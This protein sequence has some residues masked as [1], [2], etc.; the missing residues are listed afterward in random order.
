MSERAQRREPV[1]RIRYARNFVVALLLT[2]LGLILGG[3]LP[4]HLFAEAPTT[5]TTTTTTVPPENPPVISSVVA[6]DVTDGQWADATPW[7][8]VKERPVIEYT[9]LSARSG[10]ASPAYTQA[11]AVWMRVH[12]LSFGL[13]PGSTGPGR[14]PS[15]QRGPETVPA[16]GRLNLLGYFNSG[17][18]EPPLVGGQLAGFYTNKKTFFPFT[19]G[20]ATLVTYV[21]GSADVI[22][23]PYGA[24]VPSNVVTARQNLT[25]MVANH[26]VVNLGKNFYYWGLTLTVAPNGWRSGIGVDSRGNLIYAAANYQSPASLAALFVRLGAVRAME[27]DINQAWPL[28]TTFSAPNAVGGVMR[29]ANPHQYV[30]RFLRAGTT[31]DFV[32]VYRRNKATVPPPW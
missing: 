12:D 13:Y 1:L 21:D 27:L 7:A 32:A 3:M 11:Y 2:A 16:T 6:N 30:D 18:Y 17:F 31:K 8:D 10:V 26:H 19:N 29:I 4:A 25:L 24:R 23:W 5:T 22:A 20:L 15:G 9:S 14:I 28:Y